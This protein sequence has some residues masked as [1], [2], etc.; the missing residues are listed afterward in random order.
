[1]GFS[2]HFSLRAPVTASAGELA[3]FLRGVEADAKQMGFAPTLVVEGP[4]DTP[5]R[6]QFARRVARGLTVED[7][8][9]RGIELAEGLCWS[10]VPAEGLCRLAPEYGVFLVVTDQRGV[11]AVF[12]FFR[13]PVA[14]TDRQGRV[15]MPLPLDWSGRDSFGSPDP[16]YRAIVARFRDAGYLE[17]EIDEFA[18][19]AAD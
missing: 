6:R 3:A 14:I 4:F 12:G 1:M 11:E 2:Y 17:S 7:E 16:R 10:S 9:L 13:F 18:P 5:E 8:R 15:I 19:I